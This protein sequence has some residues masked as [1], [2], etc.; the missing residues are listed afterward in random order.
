MV[1]AIPAL[2][3]IQLARRRLIPAQIASPARNTSTG[4]LAKASSV[5]TATVP[6]FYRYHIG[7]N[8]TALVWYR[9]N[10]HETEKLIA[11][12]ELTINLIVPE[13]A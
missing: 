12:R 3:I 4:A 2:A 11:N 1:Y 8:R 5:G 13:T 7:T 10:C 6:N 9:L